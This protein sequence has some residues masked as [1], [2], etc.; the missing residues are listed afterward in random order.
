MYKYNPDSTELRQ[1]Y[2]VAYGDMG[3]YQL[4][5]ALFANVSPETIE[6]LYKEALT[7]VRSD[8]DKMEGAK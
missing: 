2:E 1:A 7:K 6:R 3:V 8:M 5:G 4:Y